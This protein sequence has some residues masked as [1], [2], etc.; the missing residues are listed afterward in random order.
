MWSERVKD[1]TAQWTG[2]SRGTEELLALRILPEVRRQ[3][4]VTVGKRVSETGL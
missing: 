1:E 3:A 2:N 4:G